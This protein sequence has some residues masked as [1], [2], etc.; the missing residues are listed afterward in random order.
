LE[1][2]NRNVEQEKKNRLK[3]VDVF[4]NDPAAVD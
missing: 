4:W 2:K 3:G 1:K